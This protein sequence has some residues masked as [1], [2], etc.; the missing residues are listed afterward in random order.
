MK[1][2]KADVLKTVKAHIEKLI[3]DHRAM[4]EARLPSERNIALDLGVSR[5]SVSKVLSEMAASGAILR[6][7]GSGIYIPEEVASLKR[8]SIGIGLRC[9]NY[10]GDSHFTKVINGL[11][12][13]SSRNNANIQ[14]FDRLQEHFQ[15]SDIDNKVLSALKSKLVDAFIIISRMPVDVVSKIRG[16]M[17]VVLLNNTIDCDNLVGVTSDYVKAAFLATRHLLEMGHS[18][19][20]YVTEEKNH[21]ETRFNVSGMDLAMNSCGRNLDKSL[22]LTTGKNYDYMKKN[23]LYFF[24]RNKRITAAFVRSDAV[25]SVLIKTLSASGFDIPGDISVVSV[26]NY[27]CSQPEALNMTTVDNKLES[28]AEKS[29]EAVVGML[30]EGKGDGEIHVL[31]PELIKRGTVCKRN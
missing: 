25:A 26:G 14:I 28:M 8:L 13:Y 10:I 4:N 21:P 23:I 2:K 31:E 24:K 1:F 9:V 7:H 16:H 17:P 6:R 22:C 20:A 15:V 12:S 3:K 19:I 5:G 11:S 30:R 18:E 27:A 29:I